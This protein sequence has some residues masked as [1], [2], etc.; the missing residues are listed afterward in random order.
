MRFSKYFLVLVLLFG[1]QKGFGQVFTVTSNGDEDQSTTSLRYALSHIPANTPGYTIKFNLPGSP[2]DEN[3]TIKIKTALPVI[4]SNVIIDG[5]TQPWPA[6][7]ISGAKI[8]IEPEYTNTTFNGLTIGQYYS[9]GLQTSGVEI[10]GLYLRNFAKIQSLQPSPTGGSGIVVDYRANNIK[11]GAPGKGNVFSGNINGILIQNSSYYSTYAT[12][13]ISIQSN[14]IGVFYDGTS[15]RSNVNGINASLYDCNLNIGGD[16]PGEG[17]VISANQNNVTINRYYY[18]STTT[19]F[20]INVINNKIGV[21]FNGVKDYQGI[22]LFG[23]GSSVTFYGLKIDAAYTNLY[24][25]N[26]IISG[27]RTAGVSIANADFILTGNSVGTGIAH[28]ENLSNAGV[29]IKIESGAFGTIGGTS[30]ETNYIGYNGYG[31]ESTSSKPITITRNSIF[32]NNFAGIVKS[33]NNPQ[34]TIR[35]LK[36]QPNYISGKATP[37]SSVELFYTENCGGSCQGRTYFKTVQALSSGYW[38]YSAP[39]TGSVIATATLLNM[40]TSTFSSTELTD[41]DFK[42]KHVTCNESGSITILEDREGITFTWNKL[43]PGGGKQF[44]GNSQQITGLEVGSYEVTVND[45]CKESTIPL[46]IKDQKLT[47]IEVVTTPQPDCGQMSFQFSVKVLRGSGTIKFE[48]KDVIANVIRQTTYGVLSEVNLPQGTYTVTATDDAGCS[49]SYAFNAINRKPKPIININAF[50]SI[51]A[52][53]GLQNG[54]LKASPTVNPISDYTSPVTYQWYNYN[55]TTNLVT[56]PIPGATFLDLENV[57]G[58]NWYVLKVTDA[59]ACSPVW[60]EARYIGFNSSVSISGIPYST[61]CGNNNGA[62]RNISITGADRYELILPNG[63]SQGEKQYTAMFEIPN[64]AAGTN[65]RIRARNSVNNCSNEIVFNIGSINPT[66]Y[67]TTEASQA[68]TCG[69]TNGSITITFANNTPLPVA[70]IWTNASGSVIPNQT[71]S[72]PRIRSLSGLPPGLYTMTAFDG[73]GCPVPFGPYNL[74]E[75][76]LLTVINTQIPP[77]NDGCSLSRG[78]VTGI[79]VDGGILPYRYYWLNEFNQPVK[80]V[81]TTPDLIGVPAGKYHLRV[82]DGT[83]CGEAFSA[84]YVVTNPPFPI[85]DPVFNG[86]IKVCYASDIMINVTAP[87]EGT[88]ELYSDIEGSQPIM[89]NKTGVFVFRV[90]KTGDY[91][92]K[93]RLGTC[94][95]GFTKIN[96]EVTNDNLLAMNT[97]TPNGDG[98]NDTWVI[99]GLP[100]SEVNIKLYTRSGQLIYEA[101][102]KYLKPFDGRFRGK[103]LPAGVYYYRIDLRA[104][105]APLGGSLTLLR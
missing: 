36:I 94:E 50:A 82:E 85:A 34:P 49:M 41:E 5:N 74:S 33:Q 37:N 87:E 71:N 40:T 59:G 75:T 89:Q 68:T 7:G 54:A 14:F 76:P 16:N 18:S 19:R 96:V 30:A 52:S 67:S 73:N 104:D 31:I 69:N 39:I 79:T 20:E 3:R 48:W 84:E 90:S 51:S 24:V 72:N 88:Y 101:N 102:G 25:R 57:S 53:C 38:E 63:T 43:L 99:N 83:D 27:N 86:K 46:E 97:I 1:F 77:T 105:C 70:Y 100:E 92:V 26:N 29:G 12:S 95:S 98:M 64:L 11:I 35:I 81:Q 17:N 66:A 32:C 78:S 80:P 4:P 44:L 55:R 8:I 60:S 28:T 42:V 15:E 10:Y 103:D 6:L 45:G 21:D 23:T 58:D 61:T 56:T 93:R 65:Y 62:Y 22:P 91:Y 13:S 47:P 9:T 2:S